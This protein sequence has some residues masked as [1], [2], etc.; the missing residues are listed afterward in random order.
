MPIQKPH[1]NNLARQHHSRLDGRSNGKLAKRRAPISVAKPLLRVLGRDERS[2]DAMGIKR[3]GAFQGE[4]DVYIAR[5]ELELRK[6]MAL[7]AFE[8]AMGNA[9]LPTLTALSLP[10]R[11]TSLLWTTHAFLQ[12]R[13]KRLND[14]SLIH[15]RNRDARTLYRQLA[16]LN[17]TAWAGHL[18]EEARIDELPEGVY[19][20][21]GHPM[22][23][24]TYRCHPFRGRRNF[25]Y[26]VDQYFSMLYKEREQALIALLS[27]LGATKIVISPPP[28]ESICEGGLSPITQLH[29]KVFEY[30]RRSPTLQ[31]LSASFDE[32]QHP[33]LDCEPEWKAVVEERVK[34]GALAAQFEF[35]LDIAGMLKA[36]VQAVGQLIPQLSSMEISANSQAQMLVQMLQLR[37]IKVEFS[38]L[39]R[40]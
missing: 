30:P 3:A 28:G 38:D 34:R 8:G 19:M 29:E 25:Y 13:Y 39:S 27:E 32:R 10:S 5:A 22:P 7:V 20:P 23:G 9:S 26:P 16:R 37:C 18:L 12:E 21:P 15:H 31:P 6:A 1:K 17:I 4:T 24:K 40:P 33:W 14:N 2:G 35:G 11:V 36:Q